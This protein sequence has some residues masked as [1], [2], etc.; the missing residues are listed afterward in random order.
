MQGWG[1][2]VF[3]AW[4][5]G[6][7]TGQGL[8]SKELKPPLPFLVPEWDH[9]FSDADTEVQAECVA[10]FTSL[11]RTSGL[12]LEPGRPAAVYLPRTHW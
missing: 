12:G 3:L 4:L 2:E 10:Q 1:G 11:R 5:V 9:A 8:A 6:L 7:P